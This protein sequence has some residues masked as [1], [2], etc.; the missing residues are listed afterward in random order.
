MFWFQQIRPQT[1]LFLI[2]NN[3]TYF[4]PHFLF[5]FIFPANESTFISATHTIYD[6]GYP[7]ETGKTCS[8]LD[9]K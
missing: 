6:I 3:T 4:Y 7:E 5:E 9:E 1:T 8:D 2:N